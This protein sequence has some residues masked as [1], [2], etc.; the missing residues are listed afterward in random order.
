MHLV[1]MVAWLVWAVALFAF[2]L[3]PTRAEEQETTAPRH[4]TKKSRARSRPRPREAAP[5]REAER[6]ASRRLDEL[7]TRQYL[8]DA[9]RR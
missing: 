3:E 7:I 5:S 4:S 9:G 6:E 1:F 8:R 2:P